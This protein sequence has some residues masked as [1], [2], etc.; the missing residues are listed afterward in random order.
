MRQQPLGF[1][2][3]LDDRC[4]PRAAGSRYFLHADA[5]HKISR[6]E[7]TART[8]DAACRQ[9][10]ICAGGIIAEGLRAPIAQKNAAGV[11]KAIRA[12]NCRS[13][14]GQMFR[15]KAVDKSRR[16][17]KRARDEHAAIFR[18]GAPSRIRLRERG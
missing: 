12:F 18:E 14:Q 13:A 8:R 5:F 1:S 17:C 4:E 11:F 7:A 10:V 16:V 3:L 2:K 6:G 15:R 9:H